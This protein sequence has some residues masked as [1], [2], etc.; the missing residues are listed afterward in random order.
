MG[1]RDVDVVLD[2]DLDDA[3]DIGGDQYEGYEYEGAPQ[4]DPVDYEV[5]SGAPVARVRAWAV[6]A[7]ALV[8]QPWPV[9][10]TPCSA[11]CIWQRGSWH[12]SMPDRAFLIPSCKYSPPYLTTHANCHLPVTLPP[13]PPA[14]TAPVLNPPSPYHPCHP[15]P[16]PPP[17][18]R[19]PSP[20]P[21]AAHQRGARSG[22]V[23]AGHSH[24]TQGVR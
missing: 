5:R 11:P 20:P 22:Q 12:S 9:A 16:P 1:T 19:P 18:A 17:P 15:A 6:P 7:A 3:D 10:P 21:A 8:A 13:P 24:R 2:D 23:D 14:T 4:A